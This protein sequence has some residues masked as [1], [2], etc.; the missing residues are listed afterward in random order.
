MKLDGCGFGPPDSGLLWSPTVLE[1]VWKVVKGI[2]TVTKGSLDNGNRMDSD[3]GP[4]DTASSGNVLWSWLP[5]H[6]VTE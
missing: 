2:L 3:K 5:G 6:V 1:V 4:S